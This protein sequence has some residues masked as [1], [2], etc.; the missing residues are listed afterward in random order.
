MVVPTTGQTCWADMVVVVVG[1]VVWC[2]V[3]FE[4]L[5]V[6]LVGDEECVRRGNRNEESRNKGKLPLSLRHLVLR[7]LSPLVVLEHHKLE[8]PRACPANSAYNPGQQAIRSS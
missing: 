5:R 6:V 2:W 1:D 4:W 7:C 8:R 3:V